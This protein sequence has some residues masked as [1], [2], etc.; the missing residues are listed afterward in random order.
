MSTHD[1]IVVGAGIAGAATAFFLAE[2]G[3]N[4]ALIEMSHPA[5][6]PTGR[7]SAVTH[8]FYLQSELSRL[9]IA[10]VGTL[11]RIPEL[12]SEA[13]A[14]T[15]CGMMWACGA[16]S[17]PAWRAAA[18]RITT[19]GSR[20]EPM[21]ADELARQAP[22]IDLDGIALALWEEAYGYGDPYGATHALVKGARQRG[23]TV[24]LN[25]KVT[26]LVQSSGRITGVETANGDKL[27]AP[28]VISAAGVWTKPLIAAQGYELPIHVERHIMAVLDGGGKARD[29]M[30]FSWCDDLL[31]NYARPDGDRVILAGV[32]AGGGTGIRNQTLARPEIVTDPDD[33]RAETDED[34]CLDSLSFL[35][36]RFPRLAELGV[37]PGYAGLYDMSPDDNP[38]IGPV[39]G[40]D[41]L[42]VICGS[43]GHGFKLGAGVGEEV[44]RLV[45]EGRSELL[46]PFRVDRFA[47]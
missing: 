44:A 20:I 32:W 13:P 22:G 21:S 23:A 1:V 9:A 10:G 17:A 31:C 3:A 47:A 6:G 18:E 42:F 12:T 8:A 11:R 30:P 26:R 7:S 36:P 46:A 41:G 34:E 14:H 2:R 19:E 29:F 45:T 39:P 24:Y 43:S 37:R 15:E 27:S 35:L 16:D 40:I 4:V 38:I 5:S 25:R 33:Y 28:I